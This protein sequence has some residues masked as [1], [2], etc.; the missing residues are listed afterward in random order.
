MIATTIRRRRH[1]R[2]ALNGLCVYCGVQEA[3][4]VDHVPPQN[5]FSR[6]LPGNIAKI[7]SCEG[8]NLGASKD[9]EYFRLTV[10]LRHDIAHP[11]AAVAREAA[12]RSLHRSQ[13]PGLRASLLREMR[14]AEV[15][16]P[17]GL[18]LGR[19]TTYH[20]D[21]DRLDSVVRRVTRGLFYKTLG[22][23]L[24]VDCE[25]HAYLLL[26]IEPTA[27]EAIESAQEIVRSVRRGPPSIVGRRVLM[28]WQP[29]RSTNR[30]VLRGTSCSTSVCR[31]SR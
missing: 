22:R 16:T 5:L 9:D 19:A 8:C 4:T 15:R 30:S 27:R 1:K 12:I 17:A 6:P 23:P 13:A 28:F 24:P 11:D 2:S 29:S 26:Q 10:A 18:Y 3:T 7:P 14:E 31:G 21:T 25:V 20:V